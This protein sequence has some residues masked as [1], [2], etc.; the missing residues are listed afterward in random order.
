MNAIGRILESKWA[1]GLRPLLHL[2]AFYPLLLVV[3][4]VLILIAWD[5]LM[6]DFDAFH[7]LWNEDPLTGGLAG[8][9]TATIL[10][11][12]MLAVFL[13]DEDRGNPHD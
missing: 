10:G 5:V 9:F 11:Q 12:T 2:I 6:S 4:V 3:P 13:L 1:Q 7:Q 8:F